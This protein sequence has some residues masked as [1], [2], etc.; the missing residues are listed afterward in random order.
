LGDIEMNFTSAPFIMLLFVVTL[1]IA[2]TCPAFAAAKKPPVSD[3][4]KTDSVEN[5]PFAINAVSSFHQ[6]WALE[7]EIPRRLG[8]LNDLGVRWERGDFWWHMIEPER[9]RFDWKFSDGLLDVFEKHNVQFFPILCYAPAWAENGRSPADEQTWEDYGNYVY[10]WP[11]PEFRASVRFSYDST[12][13]YLGMDV[14]DNCVTCE[15]PAVYTFSGILDHAD[16]HVL[17]IDRANSGE[18]E[19]GKTQ[20]FVFFPTGPQDFPYVG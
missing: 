19:P 12:Y 13:L 16:D 11:N 3:I 15:L 8:I 2:G 6:P 18:P 9:G 14:D 20:A 4:E 17:I 1:M 5:S 7:T 10:H